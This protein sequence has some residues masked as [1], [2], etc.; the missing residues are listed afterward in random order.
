MSGPAKS[1]LAAMALLGIAAPAHA[2]SGDLGA[3]SSAT[4]HITV[5]IPPIGPAIAAPQSGAVGVWT[6]T[7]GNDGLMLDLPT[8]ITPGVEQSFSL[9]SAY[10]GP[11][12]ATPL[13][14]S[15]TIRRGALVNDR[16]LGRQDFTLV[17]DPAAASPSMTVV[18]H[19]L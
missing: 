5:I 11:L 9:F 8:T 6:I 10:A 13:G 4:M 12:V 16:G 14:A 15:A 18:I 17:P 7:G 1:L 19:S 3:S 2:A